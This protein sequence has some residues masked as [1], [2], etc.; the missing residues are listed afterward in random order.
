M[1]AFTTARHRATVVLFGL[2]PAFGVSV[3]APQEALKE[4]GRGVAGDRRMTLRHALVVMQVALSL[5]L[6]VGAL[7]FAR[8]FTALVTR[9][10]GFDRDPV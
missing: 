10:A 9:D 1:L 3:V 7:L 8:T 5:T 2:A 6:V 4:Q